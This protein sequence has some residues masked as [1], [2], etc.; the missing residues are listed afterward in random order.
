M[1]VWAESLDHSVTWICNHLQLFLF[2]WYKVL[3]LYFFFQKP[4]F[5]ARS[6]YLFPISLFMK[7]SWVRTFIFYPTFSS[8]RNPSDRT[9][10]VSNPHLPWHCEFV[11]SRFHRRELCS[12]HPSLH[13][14]PWGG[15]KV[16]RGA[17]VR[18]KTCPVLNDK[19]HARIN[20]T[21]MIRLKHSEVLTVSLFYWIPL[22]LGYWFNAGL[23]VL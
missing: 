7:L 17:K 8:T 12:F 19:S 16:R 5:G 18:P 15:A 2:N 10:G 20:E 4:I 13:G 23:Y 11:L 6:L 14:P 21:C 3:G 22:T 1:L 9:G